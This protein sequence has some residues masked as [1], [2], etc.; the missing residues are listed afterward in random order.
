MA[1]KDQSVLGLGP[2]PQ[3][4]NGVIIYTA[5]AARPPTETEQRIE[6]ETQK[7]LQVIRNQRQQTEV[8]VHEVA[9]IHQQSAQEF[10]DTAAYLS[11]LKETA[12]GTD[13]QAQFEEFSQRTAQMLAQHLFGI[14]EVSAR[15]IGMETARPLYHEDE[16]IVVKV[17]EKRGFLRGLRRDRA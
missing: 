8:A 17:E 13:Y 5:G 3:T 9:Q 16:P 15:N 1:K 2:L 4:A 10:L 7:Q 14:S 11:A 6:L 12:K